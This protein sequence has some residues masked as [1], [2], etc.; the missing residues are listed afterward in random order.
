MDQRSN[1]K[2]HQM[3][4]FYQIREDSGAVK[5]LKEVYCFDGFR[6][7]KIFQRRESA[8][9]VPITQWPNRRLQSAS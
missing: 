7:C 3:C 4:H 8:Q 5:A 1:C 9:P 2:F 6:G